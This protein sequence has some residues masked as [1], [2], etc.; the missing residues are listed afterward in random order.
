[1]DRIGGWNV[2]SEWVEWM[3]W[4]ESVDGMGGMNASQHKQ[5]FFLSFIYLWRLFSN[6]GMAIMFPQVRGNY[7][8]QWHIVSSIPTPSDAFFLE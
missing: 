6:N 5:V 3:E 4:I 2:W 8:Y 7:L 1:M